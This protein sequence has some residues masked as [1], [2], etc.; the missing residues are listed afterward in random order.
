[1]AT[2]IVIVAGGYVTFALRH[3]AR[4]QWQPFRRKAVAGKNTPSRQLIVLISGV[5][6]A[7]YDAVLPEFKLRSGLT[8]ESKLSPS[9]GDNPDSVES[10][11][12]RGDDAD[13]VIM[14]GRGM[15]IVVAKGLVMAE[16]RVELGRAPAG[17]AMRKGASKPDI[18]T[19]DALRTTLL[20]A[21]SIGYSI[22]A[23][24]Q[25][26]SG[27]LFAKLG[28]ADQMKGKAHEVKDLIPVAETVA[29]GENQY[30]F[31]AVSEILPVDGV[32]LVGKLPDEVEFVTTVSAA[33]AAG[34]KNPDG[35]LALLR[36]LTRPEM[37]PVLDQHG[38]DAPA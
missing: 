1:M 8:I 14:A 36:F 19:A 17:L 28:I 26:V 24:G 7:A 20:S 3:G 21:S 2:L 13:V 11:L 6:H 34:S 9:L 38:L 4:D 32:E 27:E 31:Q 16:A 37:L 33:I 18:S 22:S 10:R 23:S 12:S 5:F 30:G 29:R 15:D 25:Y 35:A